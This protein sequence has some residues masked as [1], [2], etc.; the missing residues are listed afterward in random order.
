MIY[1]SVFHVL[2]WPGYVVGNAGQ[3]GLGILLL[4]IWR[5]WGSPLSYVCHEHVLCQS[6]TIGA[7][8]SNFHSLPSWLMACIMNSVSAARLLQA[9]HVVSASGGSWP[10]SSRRL[11]A[12]DASSCTGLGDLWPLNLYKRV[13]TRFCALSMLLQ[14]EPPALQSGNMSSDR[15]WIS[16]SHKTRESRISFPSS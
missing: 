11:N 3:W 14:T 16:D 12:L 2:L 9:F 7:C 15:C 13:N 8:T 6:W 10:L 5:M 4:E 1:S